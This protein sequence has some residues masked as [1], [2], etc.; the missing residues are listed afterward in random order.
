MVH[1]QQLAS[2]RIGFSTVNKIVV[3]VCEAI[4]KIV[5]Q[6]FFPEPTTEIWEKSARCF[7]EKWQFPNCVGSVDGKHVNIKYPNHSGSRNFCYL[8]TFLAVLM[9]IVDYD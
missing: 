8:K 1:F 9:A 3:E 4:I 2:F 7:Y 6:M 5:Y